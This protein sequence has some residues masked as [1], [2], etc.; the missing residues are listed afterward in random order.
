MDFKFEDIPAL[1]PLSPEHLKFF[2]YD[3]ARFGEIELLIECSND[4]LIEFADEFGIKLIPIKQQTFSVNKHTPNENEIIFTVVK[5]RNKIEML[6]QTALF[7]HL[8]NS[9][10]HY[11]ITYKNGENFF[12]M[13]DCRCNGFTMR[14]LVEIEKLKNLIFRL[15]DYNE[16]QISNI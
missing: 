1:V 13:E 12:L 11:R 14:G 3:V 15:R 4:E 6:Y 16:E 2:Y 8:R 5:N 7:K 9:F 10:A